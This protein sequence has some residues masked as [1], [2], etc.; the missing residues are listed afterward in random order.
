MNYC[1]GFEILTALAVKGSVSLAIMPYSPLK[2]ID[3]TV[4]YPRRENEVEFLF[5][6]MINA[7]MLCALYLFILLYTLYVTF[8]C[9]YLYR[10]L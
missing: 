10:L 7:Y 3:Y 9:C 1:V 4:L 8:L 2:P 6:I 5:I